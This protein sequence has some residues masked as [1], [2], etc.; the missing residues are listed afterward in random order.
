MTQGEIIEHL[1]S[2]QF[3]LIEQGTPCDVQCLKNSNQ[4]F[5]QEIFQNSIPSYSI[6]FI[7]WKTLGLSY[8]NTLN[9]KLHIPTLTKS[10]LLLN[11]IF[12]HSSPS[13][14]CWRYEGLNHPL[15]C[16][17]GGIFFHTAFLSRLK[18]NSIRC[19]DSLL[20]LLL[21]SVIHTSFSIFN[22]LNHS[23]VKCRKLN[24]SGFFFSLPMT[25]YLKTKKSR[26]HDNLIDLNPSGGLQYSVQRA[27][28]S[29]IFGVLVLL[30]SL[31]SM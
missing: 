18:S 26:H 7:W 16:V 29:F 20:K 3:F 25:N 15:I 31:R 27:D 28:T 17:E 1:T 10:R 5:L 30:D 19:I 21:S 14:R 2:Y 4:T 12:V 23:L 11:A 8:T 24:Y 22:L 13:H 6:T 9:W